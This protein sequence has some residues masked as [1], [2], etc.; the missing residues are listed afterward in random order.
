VKVV[1]PYIGELG[2]LDSRLVQLAEFLGVACETLALSQV[3]R[4]AEFLE[5][6]VSEQCSCFVVN[7]QVFKQ[8]L[9]P[10]DIPPELVIFLLSRF[11]YLLVHGLRVNAFD[12]KVVAA[13]SHGKLRSVDGIEEQC[14]EYEI[15]KDSRPFCEAF[16]GLSLGPANPI[17][18]HVFGTGGEDPAVHEL[19][20]IGGRPFMA[21]VKLG[22]AEVLFVAS[23]DVMDLNTEVGDAPLAQYF[24]RLVPQ[25]MA[26]R[27]AAGDECWRPSRAHALII[28]DDPLL[29]QRYGFLE[30]HALLRLAVQHNFHVAIAF[31]PHNFKRNSSQTTIMFLE[32]STHLSIC[33]HGNDHTAAEF[34]STDMAHLDTLLEV[35]ED[36]ME[37]HHQITGMRCDK[38]MVFPQGNFSVEGMKALKYRNFFAAVNRASHPTGRPVQ[39]TIGEL[40]QPA[41][42][43]YGG[44]P[45]FLRKPILQTDNYDIAFDL[46]F[47]RPILMGEHHEIFQHPEP[48]VE[49]AKRINSLAPDVKWSNLETVVGDSILTRKAPDGSHQ[50][51]AYSR[52]VRVSNDSCR[53][54][55]YSIEWRDSCDGCSNDRVIVDGTPSSGFEI[56][57][58]WTRISTELA[59]YTSKTFSLVHENSSTNQ[60]TLGLRWSIRAFVRRRL[61]EVRDNYLSKNPHLLAAA[62]AFQRRFLRI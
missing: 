8:W 25:A 23:E 57:G 56:D 21:A 11:P 12:S 62:V 33:F 9:G 7:P 37:L 53:T 49:I 13:L 20:S 60:A 50:V 1:V 32:N 58:G 15:A 52:T 10:G 29:R 27:Y 14:P 46:F 45:L 54:R 19:I 5:K 51:R 2:D 59:P 16:S 17:N 38:V 35:A 28:I 24:S 61:S 43:R 39:L 55:R 47:G 18:D 31:I 41:V 22:K 40:A 3:A 44:F 4:P 26:L 48:L 36:R 6:T 42:L 34:A 30:F